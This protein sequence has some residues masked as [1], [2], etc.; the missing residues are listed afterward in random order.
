MSVEAGNIIKVVANLSMPDEVLAQNV[1]YWIVSGD[2]TSTDAFFITKVED[3]LEAFYGELAGRISGA[4]DLQEA[5]VQEVE[6]DAVDGW[7]VVRNIGTANPSVTF[8]A[9]G[10]MLPHA[11][12]AI[13]TAQTAVP[14]RRSRKSIPGCVEAEIDNSTVTS[15][16]LTALANAA[17]EWISDFAIATGIVCISVLLS[18]LGITIPLVGASVPDILGSQRRRKPGVGV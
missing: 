6:F 14:T 15:T 10:D 2:A 5:S 11:G 1:F 16:L 8:S 18:E 4:V 12:A 9:T 17:V 7:V 3:W 13:I